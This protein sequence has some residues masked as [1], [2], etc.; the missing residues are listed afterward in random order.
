MKQIW[1]AVGLSAVVAGAQAGQDQSTRLVSEGLDR[2]TSSSA[3]GTLS[4]HG[5]QS[6]TG[7]GGV[8]FKTESWAATSV[9]PGA[10]TAST[11]ASFDGPGTVSSTASASLYDF[12]SIDSGTPSELL[13]VRY[14]VAIFGGTGSTIDAQPGNSNFG[15]E[16]FWQAS[17]T[18][19]QSTSRASAYT[20]IFYDGTTPT[21]LPPGQPSSTIGQ[22]FTFE[23]MI[24][25]GARSMIEL[26]LQSRVALNMLD[27]AVS[28]N[29]GSLFTQG[30]YWGGISSVTRAD[31]SLVDYTLTSDSGT[32]WTRSFAPAAAVPEPSAAWMAVAGIGALLVRRRRASATQPAGV[33]PACSPA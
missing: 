33:T 16:T 27:Y 15:G 2:T 29:G 30:I 3:F 23:T 26:S 20:W 1:F 8:T 25:S 31:G 32:D 24:R 17:Q 9:N 10:V 28:G 21:Q 18:F 7:A 14:S 4:D 19:G 6:G 5:T 22:V 12:V 11:F 13:K